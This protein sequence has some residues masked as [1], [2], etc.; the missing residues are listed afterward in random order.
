[1]NAKLQVAK[2]ASTALMLGSQG[3]IEPRV[4]FTD[5]PAIEIVHKA[6]DGGV[7]RYR[8]VVEEA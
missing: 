3:D 5:P 6:E 4:I 8:L 2:S 1:M 7:E